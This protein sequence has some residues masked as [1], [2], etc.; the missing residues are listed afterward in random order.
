M[1]E[2]VLGEGDKKLASFSIIKLLKILDSQNKNIQYEVH[3]INGNGIIVMMKNYVF[4]LNIVEDQRGCDIVIIKR[5]N[6]IL[7]HRFNPH[8]HTVKLIDSQHLTFWVGNQVVSL[9]G[10]VQPHAVV[11]PYSPPQTLM[12]K[13][14]QLKR[15]FPPHHPRVL[16]LLIETNNIVLALEVLKRIQKWFLK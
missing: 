6:T 4:F 10:K 1:N 12:S 3:A 7:Y 14:L 11:D 8:A 9:G 5:V 15:V 13:Q 2:L 16:Q